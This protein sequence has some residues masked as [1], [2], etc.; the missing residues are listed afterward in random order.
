M[1]P[2]HGKPAGFALKPARSYDQI[3]AAREGSVP[4][5]CQTIQ[6]SLKGEVEAGARTPP[7]KEPAKEP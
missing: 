3:I 6:G 4:E 2:M 1:S 7:L 5:P